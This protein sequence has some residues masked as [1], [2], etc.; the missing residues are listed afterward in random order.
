[1]KTKTKKRKRPTAYD[2]GQHELICNALN[3]SPDPSAPGNTAYEAVCV[4]MMKLNAAK[5]FVKSIKMPEAR[6]LS[7]YLNKDSDDFGVV[8]MYW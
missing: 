1:M 2:R 4:L 5:A 6:K 3:V 8:R 7:R